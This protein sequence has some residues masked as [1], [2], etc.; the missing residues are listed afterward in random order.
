MKKQLELTCAAPIG[1]NYECIV[2]P[3]IPLKKEPHG[4]HECSTNKQRQMLSLDSGL[5][6]PQ[7]S[8][9]G[10]TGGGEPGT[11]GCLAGTGGAAG[12]AGD[13]TIERVDSS[14]ADCSRGVCTY[15]A[16]DGAILTDSGM[17]IVPCSLGVCTALMRLA[18]SMPRRE[19]WMRC[20]VSSRQ[21]ATTADSSGVLKRLARH[22]TM[23]S[24]DRISAGVRSRLGRCT[25]GRRSR[26]PQRWAAAAAATAG[27]DDA[28]AAS[29]PEPAGGSPKI[30]PP[31][32]VPPDD[33]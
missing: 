3:A 12:G 5:V 1:S 27:D 26:P 6:T 28:V 23:E 18:G 2:H 33:T 8:A 7:L 13:E 31:G 14:T 19:G 16:G 4:Q 20:S 24:M 22:L 30:G 15:L 9:R 11:E 17:Q 32:G 21:L 10:D 25:G 29:P